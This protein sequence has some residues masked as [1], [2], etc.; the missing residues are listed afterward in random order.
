MQYAADI[1]STRKPRRY[2]FTTKKSLRDHK[3][4]SLRVMKTGVKMDLVSECLDRANGSKVTYSNLLNF[5][6]KLSKKLWIKLD[7]LAKRNK[8]A[9]LCWYAENWEFIRPHVADIK[10]LEDETKNQIIASPVNYDN[11]KSSQK[12]LVD[13]SNILTLLNYH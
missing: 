5:A 8:D 11:P 13:P 7:R 4:I 9:L 2:N 10:K 12:D 6:D 3:K 1:I